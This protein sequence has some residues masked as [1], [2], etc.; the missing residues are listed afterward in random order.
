VLP[1]RYAGGPLKLVVGPTEAEAAR[2]AERARADAL[3]GQICTAA[4]ASAQSTCAL[5]ELIG[6]FDAENAVR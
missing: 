5:L 4:S 1:G 6:E 3:A 2:A